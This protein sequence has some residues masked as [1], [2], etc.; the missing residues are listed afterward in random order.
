MRHFYEPVAAAVGSWLV[1]LEPAGNDCMSLAGTLPSSGGA[2]T[3]RSFSAEEDRCRVGNRK[4]TTGF[5]SQ[6][7]LSW[8]P[9]CDE[10]V[11]WRTD[12]IWWR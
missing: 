4:G 9:G 5:L 6:E 10:A 12:R 2:L 3:R 7:A 11:P 8:C 1:D